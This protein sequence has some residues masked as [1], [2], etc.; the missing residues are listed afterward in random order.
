MA[1][2][3]DESAQARDL[4]IDA[5]KAAG[6]I[7]LPYFRVGARTTAH[8]EYKSG[9][10]PVTRADLEVDAFLRE[11]LSREFPDA[12]WLSEESGDDSTRLSKTRVLVVDPIDGTRAFVDGDPRWTISIALVGGGRPLAGVVHAP[13]VGVTYAAALGSGA[14]C[15]GSPIAASSRT[16]LKGASAA[17][18]RRMVEELARR[19]AVT[20]DIRPRTPSLA[21]RLALVASGQVDFAVASANSHDW[22]IAAAD[23]ILEESGARL[24]EPSTGLKPL[25]Y[26]RLAVSRAPLLAA[27]PDLAKILL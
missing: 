15:N 20:L 8:V 14:T 18:P 22:D 1:L 11:R 3:C 27:P 5:A 2:R 16:T 6:A 24:Y 12:G 17:G 9:G 10:S 23:V 13:A 25:R 19:H 26:D 21:Y 4:L 7:A